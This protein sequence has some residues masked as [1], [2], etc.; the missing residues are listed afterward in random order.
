MMPAAHVAHLSMGRMRI[1]V[2]EKV[3]NHSYF[4]RTAREL[5]DMPVNRF[6]GFEVALDA[7]PDPALTLSTSGIHIPTRSEDYS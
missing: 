1:R 2:P 7:S 6:V 5:V 4:E 3:R